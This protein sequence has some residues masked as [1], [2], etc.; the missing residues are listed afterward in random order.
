MREVT[1]ARRLSKDFLN[2]FLVGYVYGRHDAGQD[3]LAEARLQMREFE[4]MADKLRAETEATRRKAFEIINQTRQQL[5]LPPEP[6]E[7]AWPISRH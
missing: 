6:L 2:A 5:G 4:D 7:G 3:T 1:M